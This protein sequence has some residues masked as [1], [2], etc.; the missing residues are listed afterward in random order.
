MAS[1]RIKRYSETELMRMNKQLRG[2]APAEIIHWV[3]GKVQKPVVITGFSPLDPAVLKACSAVKRGISVIRYVTAYLIKSETVPASECTQSGFFRKLIRHEKPDVVFTN[4]RRGRSNLIDTTG[5]L[6]YDKD[7]GLLMVS[8][9]YHWSDHQ[10]AV[11]LEE[12]VQVLEF[13]TFQK[14]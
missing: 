13:P 11:Y 7:C 8:P 9:F 5:I 4:F 10:V 14:N 2:I 3:M 6:S 12:H 1:N